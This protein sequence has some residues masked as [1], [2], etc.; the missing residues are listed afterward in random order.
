ML[1][2]RT[3]WP[4]GLLLLGG[5][6]ATAQPMFLPDGSSGY[7]LS[8]GYY[9]NDMTDCLQKAGELCGAAGYL[10]Y[11]AAGHVK[12]AEVQTPG[13]IAALNH[14]ASKQSHPADNS[15]KTLFIKCKPPLVPPQMPAPAVE[16]FPLPLTN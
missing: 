12:S 9:I 14:A 13:V 16:S 7:Q 11:D 15:Q 8:C 6:F 3:F 2:V 10:T 1:R 4:F 5:C